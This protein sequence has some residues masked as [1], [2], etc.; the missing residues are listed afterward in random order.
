MG[1][2]KTPWCGGTLIS[3]RHILTAAH[4]TAGETPGNIQVLLGEHRTND[5][6]FTRVDVSQINDDPNYSFPDSDFSILTLPEPV[7]ISSS[8]RPACLPATT[9]KTYEGE[10]ATV[11]GW[12]TLT[13]G[14][15]QPTV[16]MEVDVTVTTNELCNNVY[17]SINDLHICALPD[18]P[19]VYARVTQRFDWIKENTAY[20]HFHLSG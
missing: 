20:L 17:G 2:G 9:D 18:V 14:G 5:D 12:G 16:L 4:C 1:N 15:N 6:V 3:E 11:T 13:S 10:L 7:T 8:V 19:G